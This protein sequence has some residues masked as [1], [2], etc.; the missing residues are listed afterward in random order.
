MDGDERGITI[1]LQLDRYAQIR[2]G[3]CSDISSMAG[4]GPVKVIEGPPSAA[5]AEIDKPIVATVEEPKHEFKPI[6]DPGPPSAAAAEAAA[7]RKKS[8]RNGA[9][10]NSIREE[11]FPYHAS[12]STL[13]STK[14]LFGVLVH[15]RAKP[16][17][18]GLVN[19]RRPTCSPLFSP[20]LPP[21]SSNVQSKQRIYAY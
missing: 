3:R 14:W 2:T 5:A 20:F 17:R 13:A 16:Q 19:P 12:G 1:S 21:E 18:R 15:F 6:A 7:F 9:Y 10:T 4:S 11:R 8:R